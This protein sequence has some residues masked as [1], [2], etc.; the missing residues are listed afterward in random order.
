MVSQR[1]W[2]QVQTT[3]LAHRLQALRPS[4][5]A[6]RCTLFRQVHATMEGDANAAANYVE[7]P[8]LVTDTARNWA[9]ADMFKPYQFS[10]GQ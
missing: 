7:G 10:T 6:D 4:S 8:A 3:P 2:V 1:Q 5:A 9:G